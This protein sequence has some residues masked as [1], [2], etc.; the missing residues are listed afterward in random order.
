MKTRMVKM[1]IK[2][3]K[4]TSCVFDGS[5]KLWCADIDTENSAK[6]PKIGEEVFIDGNKIV[7]LEIRGYKNNFCIKF[8]HEEGDCE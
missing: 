1:G 6:P 4:T 8:L 3:Y 7:V 5:D 2:E